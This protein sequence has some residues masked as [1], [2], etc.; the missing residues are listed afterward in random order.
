[1]GLFQRNYL[2]I[3]IKSY[4]IDRNLVSQLSVCFEHSSTVVSI[5]TSK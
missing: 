5:I 4:Q 1:M 2:K 3:E